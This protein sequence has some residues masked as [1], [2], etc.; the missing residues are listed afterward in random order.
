MG[1]GRW[2]VSGERSRS[3]RV[4]STTPL[5]YLS[6][7]NLIFDICCLQKDTLTRYSNAYIW[8][9]IGGDLV[10]EDEWLEC[11]TITKLVTIAQAQNIGKQRRA[12]KE[13]KSS[14]LWAQH[15]ALSSPF[16]L[17][18]FPTKSSSGEEED[19]EEEE[20]EEEEDEDEESSEDGGDSL[21]N[22]IPDVDSDD[23]G[24]N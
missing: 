10:K 9:Q 17:P 7:I 18:Q 6:S 22:L 4:I 15:L 8:P 16:N 12:A 2:A 20:E 13:F 21:L 3:H 14:L 5:I 11:K 19:E 1:G 24:D 23:S